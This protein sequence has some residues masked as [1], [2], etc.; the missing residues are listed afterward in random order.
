MAIFEGCQGCQLFSLATFQPARPPRDRFVSR[1]VTAVFD[2]TVEVKYRVQTVMSRRRIGRCSA[3]EVSMPVVVVVY[4]LTNFDE[5]LELFEANPPPKVGHW[6]VVRGMH[7]RNRVHVV[8]EV[9][10]RQN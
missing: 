8:G 2:V 7:D 5:W 1:D 3:M 10:Q 9:G 4:R 6:R